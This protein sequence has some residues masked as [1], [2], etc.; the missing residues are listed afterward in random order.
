MKNYIKMNKNKEHLSLGNFC[1]VVKSISKNK[2]N[3]L[4]N[5]V[6]MC[7][8]DI[9]EASETAINNYC[10]GL[11]SINSIYKEKYIQYK[12]KYQTNKNILHDIVNNLVYIITGTIHLL[13]TIKK[14]NN[15][16]QI[17][18]LC[19]ELYIIAKNDDTVD[20]L[21]S[22]KL[23][24]NI[25][26]NNY[27][28]F[29]CE[30]LFF[31]TLDK[32][33]P[34]YTNELN[35]KVIDKL[36]NNTNIPSK[37]LEIFLNL[38]FT[39]GINYFH[40]LK[41]LSKENNAYAALELA[42]GEFKGYIKGKPR[43]DKAYEYYEI[44]A[45]Q[46]H[47]NALYMLGRLIVFDYVQNKDKTL[48]YNY[49]LKAHEK[50]SVAATSTIGYM[51]KEGIKPLKKDIKKSIELLTVASLCDYAYANN[52]LGK[53]YEDSGDIDLSI[54]YYKK[55]ADQEESY[56]CNKM[57]LHYISNNEYE[58]AYEYFNKGID[59]EIL[60][61]CYYNYYNLSKYFYLTGNKE[62]N[63]K[64]N[65]T[66]A[67]KYLEIASS[68]NN[69]ES[70]ILLLEV[71]SNKYIKDKDEILKN[72]IMLLIDSI[73]KHQKFNSEEKLLIENKLKEIDNKNKIDIIDINFLS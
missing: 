35:Y 64:Q 58:K 4:Q 31:I 10:I 46:N 39:E 5:Q 47:P 20:K 48:G 73:E 54:K 3:A 40:L 38:K 37:D 8:F 6:F 7:I 32:K 34:V 57:G 26:E 17:K 42:K 50:G 24:T 18:E 36:L 23:Y 30:V 44:A 53:I 69:Y 72:K 62:L 16:P 19:D 27:Y 41:K 2:N 43:F 52:N 21:L 70:M 29:I 9:E 51:Y 13:P 22:S 68:Y 59:S 12:S 14:I 55:S 28:E 1:D 25:S 63:I 65:N 33:Q 61:A 56:A 60:N 45:K 71:Y 66:I 49:L 11:R 15:I 67:I